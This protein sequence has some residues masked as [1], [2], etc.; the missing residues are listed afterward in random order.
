MSVKI[1]FLVLLIAVGTMSA[2][3]QKTKQPSL[4][5]SKVVQ[6]YISAADFFGE[7]NGSE[8]TNRFFRF[9]L[10]IPED[11]I[12]LNR[13][14]V[15]IY[16]RAGTDRIKGSTERKTPIFDK[17]AQNTVPL[18]AISR[19]P[20]GTPD[21]AALEI[22]VVK[23]PAG[24]TASMV[25]ALTVKAMTETSTYTVTQNLGSIGFGGRSFAAVEAETTAFGVPQKQ[26]TFITMQSGYALMITVAYFSENGLISF[27][28]MLKSLKFNLK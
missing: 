19:K 10:I 24:A 12:V 22:V 6:N 27:D 14:E 2:Y 21:N 4:P 5:P 23:Q 8:Y 9:T 18:I 7:L 1:A 25:L 28:E 3:A 13:E 16:S 20:P 11:Y 15:E 26:R 17:A